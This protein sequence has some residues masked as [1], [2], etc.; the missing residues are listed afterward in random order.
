MKK[1]K[2]KL[3]YIIIIIVIIS[4]VLLALTAK[5]GNDEANLN[6]IEKALKDSSTF[7]QKIF[8]APIKYVKDELEVLDEKKDLYKKYTKLKEKTDKTDLYYS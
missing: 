2:T 1:K 5:M 8:Y 6:F 3:K 4:A 7:I